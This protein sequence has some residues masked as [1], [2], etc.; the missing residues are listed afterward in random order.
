MHIEGSIFCKIRFIAFV[1]WR[2]AKRNKN[3][4]KYTTTAA[5]T[6]VNPLKMLP[7]NLSLICAFLIW[8]DTL[9]KTKDLTTL[10]M[11]IRIIH[12]AQIEFLILCDINCFLHFLENYILLY[13]LHGIESFTFEPIIRIFIWIWK[14]RSK[15]SKK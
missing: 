13:Q 14:I 3:N 10:L 5:E 12:D 11:H 7:N 15:F 2:W 8:E 9:S 4:K 1:L 6:M